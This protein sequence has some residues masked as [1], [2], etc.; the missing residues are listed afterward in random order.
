M[1]SNAFGVARAVVPEEGKGEGIF[2]GRGSFK[3]DVWNGERKFRGQPKLF[4]LRVN[5]QLA[6]SLKEN[7]TFLIEVSPKPPFYTSDTEYVISPTIS[8]PRRLVIESEYLVA[9]IHCI[10]I[11]D[12]QLK[13]VY[14]VRE[15][16]SLAEERR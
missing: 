12:R 14:A 1:A 6:R 5:N 16:P 9:D 8:N 11:A 7:G 15:V 2:L 13:H 4:T 10:A 3:Y